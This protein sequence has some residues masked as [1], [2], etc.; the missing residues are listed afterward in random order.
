MRTGSIPAALA[1]ALAGACALPQTPAWSTHKDPRGFTVDVPRG[2]RVASEGTSGRV[3]AQGPGK[4][5]VIVWPV[6]APG[7]LEARAAATVLGQLAAAS[8][9]GVEWAAP[10]AA[11]PSVLRMA[12]RG[13][14]RAAMASL[15]WV[16]TPRGTAGYLYVA[17]APEP[18]YRASE[19]IFAKILASFRASGAAAGSPP[20]APSM[21]YL[22]WEDPRE[23]AFSLEYPSRWN[24]SGGL[25]RMA[26]VDTRAAWEIVSPEGRIRLTGGDA[27]I[28]T[29][30]EP[31]QV[32]MM[33]GFREGSWYSPGYGVNMLVRSYM[34]GSAF[35]KEYIGLR[36]A[37]SC[38]GL[39]FTNVRDRSDAAAGLNAIYAQFATY[40]VSTQ[41]SAGD[42]AF[43]CRKDGQEMAG[44]YFAAVRRTQNAGMPG[45]LW[46]I[47]YLFGYLA[48]RSEEP[49]ARAVLEHALG[50]IEI[51]P[52]WMGMQQNVTASTSKI[53]SQTHNE[54]SSIITGT[55]NNRQG[56][57]DEI[58]RRRS[59][60]TLGLE[61]VV[62]PA[63]GRQIKV[64][65]G[66]N[67]YWM[68]HRGT[69]VGTGTDTRP[70]LDF[71]ELTRLP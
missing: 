15:A 1:L 13:A 10:Q 57:M 18:A 46:N 30:T 6:F 52:Q 24:V 17:A 37:Q 12:G 40:G 61:D 2:W 3:S 64:E 42:A 43:T 41:L 31:N 4:E 51:N 26:A 22:R 33:S 23:K 36:V 67:Y 35:V 20:Q 45:G 38:E 69:I 49:L 68:D 59:N 48:A 19:A 53:V 56:V 39:A 27:Q 16:V 70:N 54:I 63:T 29:F 21:S 47:E 60:V 65:S 62:D 8:I 7:G 50:S 14:G 11:G 28:P 9:P 71:R 32:L 66:A 55:F 58:S 25:F 5:Q 34:P 44:Y